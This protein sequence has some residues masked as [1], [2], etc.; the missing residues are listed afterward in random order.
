MNIRCRYLLLLL[1]IIQTQ[2]YGQEKIR[3]QF[4]FNPPVP[5]ADIA[6]HIVVEKDTVA[7]ANSDTDLPFLFEQKLNPLWSGKPIWLKP[8]VN[9]PSGYIVDPNQNLKWFNS[10]KKISLKRKADIYANFLGKAITANQNNNLEE[11]KAAFAKI[12]S[13]K[14]E[15]ALTKYQ[16]FESSL[17]M[18]AV[19]NKEKKYSTQ[20]LYLDSAY[21]KSNFDSLTE[22]QR[23]RY[24][25]ERFNAFL[26]ANSYNTLNYPINDLPGLVISDSAKLK[27]WKVL[28]EQIGKYYLPEKLQE[29][30]KDKAQLQEQLI[31]F[32]RKLNAQ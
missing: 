21:N 18:G 2:L 29:V 11:A 20:L 19:F 5:Y 17:G 30:P 13:N 25:N 6:V 3:G 4:S 28:V 26:A 27:S 1:S 32:N 16:I 10:P 22:N 9:N 7:I 15:L 8:L 14:D 12:L 24:A 23:K 31:I